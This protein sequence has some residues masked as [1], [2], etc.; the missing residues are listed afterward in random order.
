MKLIPKFQNGNKFYY[1]TKNV[2]TG[3]VYNVYPSAI[4]NWLNDE[5]NPYG[6]SKIWCYFR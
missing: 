4:I 6:D 3:D 5:D 2:N 1:Q